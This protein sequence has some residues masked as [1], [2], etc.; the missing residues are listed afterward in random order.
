MENCWGIT[1][2]SP[3]IV[4]WYWTTQVA[5]IS[6]S[7]IR[8]SDPLMITFRWH[9]FCSHS[10]I[11][12]QQIHAS[13]LSGDGY[14]P[15]ATLTG[16]VCIPIASLED[17]LGSRQLWTT[18][19]MDDRVTTRMLSPLLRDQQTTLQYPEKVLFFYYSAF[20]PL[21]TYQWHKSNVSELHIRAKRQAGPI[22]T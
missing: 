16:S 19:H 5:V 2:S 6:L 9:L 10:I 12:G 11:P 4:Q 21:S 1:L 17:T 8:L 13:T 18:E 7:Y 22:N 3:S 14:A 20:N 15:Y